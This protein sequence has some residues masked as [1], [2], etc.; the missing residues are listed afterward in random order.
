MGSACIHAPLPPGASGVGRRTNPGGRASG[1]HQGDG[2]SDEDGTG[3]GLFRGFD[4]S[5]GTTVLHRS[6]VPI[7]LLF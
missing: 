2:Q 1:R 5:N 6:T 3:D 7:R 4:P